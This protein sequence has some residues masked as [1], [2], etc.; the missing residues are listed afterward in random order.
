MFLDSFLCFINRY[1]ISC[2]LWAQTPGACETRLRADLQTWCGQT[3]QNIAL[4]G[5]G[6]ALNKALM[7]SFCA[8][9]NGWL[10]QWNGSFLAKVH[11]V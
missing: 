7:I 9:D 2:L 4:A 5:L 10:L 3:K 6:S 11:F 1:K 8:I